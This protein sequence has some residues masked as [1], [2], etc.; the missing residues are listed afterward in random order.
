MGYTTGVFDLFHVGHLNIL[1]KAKECCEYL[2]V[3]VSTDEV[4]QGY[5][6]KTPIIPFNERIKIVEA[7]KYVDQVVPQTTLD[8]YTAWE[9]LK[10]DVLF[11]GDDWK[12]SDMYIEIEKKLRK[13]GVDLV[14]F[15][16]TVGTSSTILGDIIESLLIKEK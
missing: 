8:K 13:V 14:F 6:N 4:V 12:G 3:G 15:P 5:K 7:I 9:L 2:I 16:Y 11:H 1:E 10:Y